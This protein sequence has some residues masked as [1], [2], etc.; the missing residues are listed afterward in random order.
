LKSLVKP[1]SLLLGCFARSQKGSREV[2]TSACQGD[3]RLLK[4]AVATDE[5]PDIPV[6]P[7]ELHNILAWLRCIE[8]RSIQRDYFSTTAYFSKKEPHSAV[9]HRVFK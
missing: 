7:E 4:E 6:S 8:R 2:P 3:V 9:R 5:L 1:T